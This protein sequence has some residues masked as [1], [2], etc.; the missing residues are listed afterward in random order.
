MQVPLLNPFAA[1]KEHKS[2]NHLVLKGKQKYEQ[3]TLLSNSCDTSSR[4]KNFN[5]E[6]LIGLQIY[7]RVKQQ[8]AKKNPKI[9]LIKNTKYTV[10]SHK[11]YTGVKR[12]CAPH[13][14]V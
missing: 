4:R 11:T 5:L 7:V 2:Q 8:E 6:V 1:K 14:G 9:I 10:V 3:N 12:I 13:D